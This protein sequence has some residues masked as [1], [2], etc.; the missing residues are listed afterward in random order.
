MDIQTGL[1]D[2]TGYTPSLHVIKDGQPME[3]SFEKIFDHSVYT[4]LL[5]VTY[6]ASPRFF[7]EQT[8]GFEKIQLIL[9]I[10]DPSQHH[11]IYRHFLDQKK[12]LDDWHSFPEE[13][14]ENLL[15]E[16]YQLRYPEPGTVI[17]SKFYLMHNPQTNQKRIAVGSANFTKNAL[18]QPNQYEELLVYDDP[19]L[20]NVYFDRFYALKAKTQDYIPDMVRRKTKEETI[21]LLPNDP[22][23]LTDLLREELVKLSHKEIAVS[24]ETF[25]QLDQEVK[26][27]AKS[28]EIADRVNRLVLLTHKSDK[29]QGMKKLLT[30]KQLEQKIP[31]IRALISP[32]Y[33]RKEHLDPRP[34]LI[35]DRGNL[36]LYHKEKE[37]ERATV[38]SKPAAIETIREQLQLIHRFV[39]AYRTFTSKG[40]VANQKRV[41]EAILYA[42]VSPYIWKMREDLIL[43][44]GG[45]ASQR[46]QFRPFLVLAGRALSGKTT[47][48]EFIADL[49]GYKG[50]TKFISYSKLN[51]ADSVL[52]F[53]ESELVAP[54]L[55]DEISQA[56]FTGTAGERVTKMGANDLEGVHPCL[57]GTTNAADF[58][59]ESQ[60]ARRIYCLF[61][62]NTF[63]TNRLKESSEYLFQIKSKVTTDL[64][65]DFTYRLA[66][67][68][69]GDEPFAFED[70]PVRVARLIFKEYYQQTGLSQPPYFPEGKL[71]DYYERG[72]LI[73]RNLYI[74]NKKAFKNRKDKVFV[75]ID[76]LT[77]KGERKSRKIL[78]S[79]IPADIV[80]EET[81][82]LVLDRKKFFSFIGLSHWWVL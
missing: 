11:Q 55:M 63:D 65:R 52:P 81:G 15:Q 77:T 51:R 58:S 35:V 4:E 36:Y 24:E 29:K 49:M 41:Y 19:V 31:K 73:W 47:I 46:S 23:L 68:I 12:R 21:C 54:V 14:K 42:F 79:Y 1:F 22:D 2:K 3:L 34:L 30:V 17:H 57:I 6:V 10:A 13:V 18:V 66:Q 78:I 27:L 59:M 80:D 5:A 39:E 56:F 61:I 8:N 64:F 32:T 69:Q 28:Q 75:N 43:S 20:Y 82:V 74:Q 48:L 67:R 60:L 71:N 44:G 7:F 45:D 25:N 62:S 72:K 37:D 33:Q 16:R 38:F 53:M 70:D 9:G 50:T 26:E 40:D 76:E